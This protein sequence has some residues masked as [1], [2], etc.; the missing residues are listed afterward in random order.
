MTDWIADFGSMP[1]RFSVVSIDIRLS[2]FHMER[3]NNTDEAMHANLAWDRKS[4]WGL[5]GMT[6]AQIDRRKAWYTGAVDLNPVSDI[7]GL[8]RSERALSPCYRGT[9]LLT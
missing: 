6:K 1:S 7:L 9:C 4:L 2:V 3:C 8:L 5:S